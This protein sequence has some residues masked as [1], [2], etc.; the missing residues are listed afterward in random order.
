MTGAIYTGPIALAK[1]IIAVLKAD[2]TLQAAC[3]SRYGRNLRYFVGY[4]P[5]D[6]PSSD[7]CPHVAFMP[8]DYQRVNT[9]GQADGEKYCN[10]KISLVVSQNNIDKT[11][12]TTTIYDGLEDLEAI[13]PL[14]VNSIKSTL[15]T[16]LGNFVK[17]GAINTEISYPLFR[18]TFDIQGLDNV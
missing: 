8:D 6:L 10:L 18:A 11:D 4:D 12:T 17:F 9:R 5:N 16:N 13:I 1:A 15:L 3:Q 7:Q 2:G 14:V